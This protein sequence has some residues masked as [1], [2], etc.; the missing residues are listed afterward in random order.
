MT[1]TRL[2]VL[3]MSQTKQTN[4]DNLNEAMSSKGTQYL[5][6]AKLM[7]KVYKSAMDKTEEKIQEAFSAGYKRGYE[8]GFEDGV[9]KGVGIIHD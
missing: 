7:R 4:K 5:W 6:M 9:K 8:E 1:K 3:K 2:W